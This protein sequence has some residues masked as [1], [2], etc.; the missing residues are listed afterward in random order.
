MTWY[1]V[2]LN[3]QNLWLQLDSSPKRLGFY[4]T[5]FVEANDAEHAELVAVKLLREEGKLSALNDRGDPP[6]VFVERVE[7][8]ELA[9]VP[10][11]VPGFT[12]YPDD[13]DPNA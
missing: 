13:R 7:E 8:V 6:R 3:G 10:A 9:D 1:R 4:T 11:V 2:F 5:R 12:F